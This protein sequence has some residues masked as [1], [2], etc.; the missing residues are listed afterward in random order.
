MN[1]ESS[2]VFIEFREDANRILRT[3]DVAVQPSLNENLGGSLEALLMECPTVVTRVGGLVDSVRDG[4][5]G[6][7]VNPSDPKDL[8]RGIME[9]LR[10]RERARALGKAGR[11]LMLDRFTLQHTVSDLN[12]IYQN[13]LADRTQR[14]G[15]YNLFVTLWRYAVGVPLFAFMAVR[16]FFWDGYI[17]YKIRL[18]LQRRERKTAKGPLSAVGPSNEFP[19][20]VRSNGPEVE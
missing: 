17:F 9:L 20:R 13:A 3:S 11:R 2:V 1:L 16:L 4:E 7:L 19:D 8:A 18:R 15:S 10:D 5:T 14:P 6:V 12:L